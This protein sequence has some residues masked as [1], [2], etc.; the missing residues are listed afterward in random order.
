MAT[1]KISGKVYF[2]NTMD[3]LVLVYTVELFFFIP[4]LRNSLNGQ[5]GLG[6]SFN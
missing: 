5:E 6:N 2:I 1:Q 3:V 4:L